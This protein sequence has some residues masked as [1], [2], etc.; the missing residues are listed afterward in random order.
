MRKRNIRQEVIPIDGEV[1]K[2]SI[3]GFEISNYGRLKQLKRFKPSPGHKSGVWVDKPYIRQPSVNNSGYK[4]VTIEGKIHLIHRLVAS[5]FIPNPD[6]LSDVDHINGDKFNNCADNLRWVSHEDNMRAYR[7]PQKRKEFVKKIVKRKIN[8]IYVVETG[9]CL[10]S[11]K[12]ASKKLNI[13][14]A[15]ISQITS[16]KSAIFRGNYKGLH[17]VKKHRVEKMHFLIRNPN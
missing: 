7:K 3:E 6:N 8:E 4:T 5:A 12:E 14:L 13:S 2:P 10:G 1:W 17:I 9:E 11:I 15:R 16:S